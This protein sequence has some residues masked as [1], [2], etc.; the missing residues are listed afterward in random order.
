MKKKLVLIDGNALVHRAFHA[1]P[2][3]RS[4]KGI[5]TNAVFGFS[6]ILIR[7]I[8]D[9]N[10]KY[11]AATFDLPGPTFRHKQFEEY[12]AK[13]VKA[14][15]ELYDQIPIVKDLLTK[16]GIPIYEKESYEADDLIGTVAERSG[17][18]KDL[19][20]IIAT[21]DLD[22]LQLVKSKKVVVFTLKRG[23]NDT[24]TYDQD[25]VMERF[26]IK[27]NQMSDYRGLKGDP[28]DNIPGVP[29][30]GEKTAISLIQEFGSIEKLYKAIESEKTGDMS[31]KLVE[32]LRV[33]KDQAFF[34]KELSQ[35]VTDLDI[36]FSL[37]KTD[38]RN[39]LNYAELEQSFRELGFTSLIRRLEDIDLQQS[40]LPLIAETENSSSSLKGD[41]KELIGQLANSTELVVDLHED[42]LI[43]SA[44]SKDIYGISINSI[45]ADLKRTD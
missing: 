35:I 1:L 30:V 15:Q 26:G 38:W 27:P 20:T 16:M 9:F 29:G 40:G 33:N 25:A 32:K 22:T 18:E 21:G 17:K 4:P 5:I 10:P 14:P 44:N 45:S 34:S 8:K 3:L 11:I 6:S 2:P 37:A 19:Q 13:R 43:L 31:P 24:I 28:S 39:N 7:I 12:K 23:V 41:Q 36:D 42:K